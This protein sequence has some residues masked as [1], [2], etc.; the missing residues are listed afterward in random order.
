V[1]V[2]FVLILIAA[3]LLMGAKGCSESEQLRAA[4][5]AEQAI[6][7]AAPESES[8]QAAR[9]AVIDLSKPDPEPT[10]EPTPVPA[11]TPTPP[12]VL[13][14]AN[15][16]CAAGYHCQEQ[17]TGPVCVPDTSPGCAFDEHAAVALDGFAPTMTKAVTDAMATL[18]DT[19]G[20]PPAA[21]LTALASQLVASGHCAVAGQEAVFVRRSVSVWEEYHAV[22]FG[23]GALIPGGKYMGAHREAGAPT[24]P[25]PTSPPGDACPAQPCPARLWTAETLPEGWSAL[26][27]GTPRWHFNSRESGRLWADHTPVLDR[28]EPHCRAIGM[29]PRPNGTL[30]ADCPVRPDGHPEREMVER[31]LLQGDP[32]P[33]SRD[34]QDCDPDGRPLYAVPR[35]SGN[36][37]LCE[38]GR[39][40]DPARACG[41]WW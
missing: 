6:C 24:P 17:A 8:C 21:T 40:G 31:W 18:G 23:T 32:V 16:D 26:V 36:C 38:P 9:Q 27:V 28:D 29:S 12:P 30:R 10:A 34:R 7:G 1:L 3:A 14:C 15:V 20:A 41:A 22:F 37:R 13:T 5:E 39:V 25:P 4:K 33:D 35:G 11:P 19:T 2:P